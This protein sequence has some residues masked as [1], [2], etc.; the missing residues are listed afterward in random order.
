[1]LEA[2]SVISL[3]SRHGGQD[4]RSRQQNATGRLADFDWS[5]PAP[6]IERDSAPP[7]SVFADGSKRFVSLFDFRMHPVEPHELNQREKRI[8][9][10]MRQIKAAARK[11]EVLEAYSDIR[12]GIGSSNEVR[13]IRTKLSV[14]AHFKYQ[15]LAANSPYWYVVASV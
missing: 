7:P 6:K 14:A 4:H 10:D 1:M 5:S 9:K 2:P 8:V 15:P 13:C 3:A 11:L 12:I